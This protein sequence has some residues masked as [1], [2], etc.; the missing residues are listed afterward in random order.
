MIGSDTLRA[1]RLGAANYHRSLTPFLDALAKRGTQFKTC[2]VPCARTAPSLVSLMTGTWP[3]THGVRDNFVGDNETRLPVAALPQILADHGYRT[4]AVSDW[5]GGDLGKFPLGFDQLDLPK[6]QWN[7][8][9]LIRQGPKDLRLFLS[10]FT[11]NHIG[12]RILPEIYYLAGIPLTR[13]VGSDARS[14]ISELAQEE[15]PFF[16][17][18]FISTTHPPF[19]SEYPYYTLWSDPAYAGESKFVMARLTDPWEIIRRQ[20][21][22]R[23]EFDLDQIID[24][25]DG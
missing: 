10:L 16:L 11:H 24:L 22:T 21:D 19:G 13:L 2:Y 15:R 9:Y 8:K 4:A 23:K 18:V 6:D 5:S 25:Y 17:N 20:G 14:L 12:K 1:D 7:I 3:H